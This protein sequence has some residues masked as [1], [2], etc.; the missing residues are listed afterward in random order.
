MKTLEGSI[1]KSEKEESFNSLIQAIHEGIKGTDIISILTT[2][3][4]SLN[5]VDQ[6]ESKRVVSVVCTLLFTCVY[7]R[8]SLI[9]GDSRLCLL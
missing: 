2:H 8:N 4:S 6:A 7:Y 9:H 3:Y 5:F 1:K